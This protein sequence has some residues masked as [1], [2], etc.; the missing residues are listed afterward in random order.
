M[1]T[2]VFLHGWGVGPEN[3]RLLIN[4]LGK[5]FNVIAPNLSNLTDKKDFSWQKFA[6]NLD[7]LIVKK[8]IYLV[9][10]S[11]GGGLALTYAAFYPQKVKAVI[12]CEP[13]G[14]KIKRNK[15]IWTFLIIKMVIRALFYP[16]GVKF[17]PKVCF[18]F[19]KECILNFRKIYRQAKLVSGKGLEEFLAKIQAPVY[20][21]WSKNSNLL[22]LWMGERLHQG[23]VTSRLYPSFS[24]KNHLWGLFEQK[25]LAQKVSKNFLIDGQ[26]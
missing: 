4:S 23:I 25:K 6:E 8:Q 3:S 14:I 11:L 26:K 22:P 19:L 12:A 20:L 9:G 16:E 17:I 21:L 10:M 15:I 18:S 7:R 24:N 1:E 5:K 2:I 13:A